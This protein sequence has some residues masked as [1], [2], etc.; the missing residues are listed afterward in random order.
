[1]CD[2]NKMQ[3]IVCKIRSK[4]GHHEFSP[5]NDEHK[6][7][8]CLARYSPRATTTNQPT[9]RAPNEPARP[10]CAQES[11][12]W[13]KNGRFRAKHPYYVGREQKFWYPH[14]GK[15]LRHLVRIVILVMHG[16]K[17][18]RKANIWPK[19]TKTWGQMWPFFGQKS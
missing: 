6:V 13:S 7:N 18:I 9:N 12:F 11:I 4:Q 1:M 5:N 8:R 10:L 3:K 16:G 2:M 15:P 14:I 19:M 17:W